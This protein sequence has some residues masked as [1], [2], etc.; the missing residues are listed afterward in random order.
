MKVDVKCSFLL[1]PTKAYEVLLLVSALEP[2]DGSVPC[3]YEVILGLKLS[4]APSAPFVVFQSFPEG[5]PVSCFQVE[6]PQ[7][8]AYCSVQL[9]QRQIL[10]NTATWSQTEGTEGGTGCCHRL[11]CHT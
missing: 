1:L 9:G 5:I 8:L 6:L 7:Q 4:L 3:R 2:H 11:G 10:T